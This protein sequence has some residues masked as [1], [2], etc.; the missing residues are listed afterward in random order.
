MEQQPTPEALRS[1]ILGTP[2]LDEL[3]SLEIDQFVR[4]MQMLLVA[5]QTTNLTAVKEPHKVALMHFADS[6]APLRL[7]PEL[8]STS[9]ACDVGSG[10]GFPMLPLAILMPACRWTAIESIHKKCDFI[11]K[12]AAELKLNTR[13][14]C[15]RAED[16]GRGPLRG[17]MDIVTSRAVGPVVSL[18]EACLPLLKVGGLLL[19]HKTESA[20][21]ELEQ[22]TPVVRILGGTVEEVRHYGF[23]GDN[24]QRAI[25]ALRKTVKTPA[26]Y[27]RLAGVPFKNPLK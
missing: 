12:A 2:W 21:P 14:E 16:A 20:E 13:V 27:P 5:T 26:K 18:A 15:T 6:L 24:Q 7:F 3:T 9:L 1:I 8:A 25:F 11:R 23:P 22:A 4:L 17:S 19:L 10:A